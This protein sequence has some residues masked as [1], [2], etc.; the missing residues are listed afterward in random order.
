MVSRPGSDIISIINN[1][2]Y[3]L[4]GRNAG[5]REASQGMVDGLHVVNNLWASVGGSVREEDHCGAG[6]DGDSQR[7]AHDVHRGV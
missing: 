4:E 3:A 5:V 6:R 7:I 2:F 1:T